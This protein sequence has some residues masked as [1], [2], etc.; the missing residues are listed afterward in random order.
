MVT[1]E[2][3]YEVVISE[4]GEYILKIYYSAVT[5]E[6]VLKLIDDNYVTSFQLKN[7]D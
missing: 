7:T 5:V 1:T 2:Y 3:E 4:E 6:Y